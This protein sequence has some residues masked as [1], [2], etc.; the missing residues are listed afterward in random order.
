MYK[1]TKQ[2]TII[3]Q[4]DYHGG[5]KPT[6]KLFHL[7]FACLCVYVMF[8][9]HLHICSSYAD[10]VLP[11]GHSTTRD[12]NQSK[13]FHIQ[14]FECFSRIYFQFEF[15]ILDDNNIQI[16]AYPIKGCANSIA[17]QSFFIQLVI[18][19]WSR[20]V[21]CPLSVPYTEECLVC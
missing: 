6:S 4:K 7:S 9:G 3:I 14:G 11:T 1:S 8:E 15:S 12:S 20:I 19:E 21:L 17:V 5:K 18:L 13:H 16:L 10:V 2:D